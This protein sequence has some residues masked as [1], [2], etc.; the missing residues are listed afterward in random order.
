M[1]FTF[2]TWNAGSNE[3]DY[4]MSFL[5]RTD[6]SAESPNISGL[7]AKS[8]SEAEIAADNSFIHDIANVRERLLGEVAKDM[9]RMADVLALQ[10][11]SGYALNDAFGELEKNVVGKDRPDIENFVKAEFLI[12]RPETNIVEPTNTDTAI[13]INPKKFEAIENRSFVPKMGDSC[14]IAVATEKATG[15]RI[16]F[17]SG[18]MAGV[19]L[20]QGKESDFEDAQ[21]GDHYIRDLLKY[22]DKAFLDCDTII[23]GADVNA[24]PEIYK[25]R[26]ELFEEA[27]FSV[28]RTGKPTQINRKSTTLPERELDYV[29]VRQKP[30]EEPKQNRFI[31]FLSN[32][33]NKRTVQV[34]QVAPE[35]TKLKLDPGFCPSDHIPVFVTV[36]EVTRKGIFYPLISNVK[37]QLGLDQL[38]KD[39]KKLEAEVDTYNYTKFNA[40]GDALIHSGLLSE[41]SRE[42]LKH[43][44]EDLNELNKLSEELNK[45]KE[46]HLNADASELSPRKQALLKRLEAL[47]AIIQKERKDSIPKDQETNI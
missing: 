20:E 17:V 9:A 14:A 32:L 12:I 18:H 8:R 46:G 47:E 27:G 26:F 13:A 37:K 15:K 35:K 45:F 40:L 43:T 38:T 11:V 39:L 31:E 33:F 6:A 16:A 29:F 21:I 2:G 36:E 19:R 5:P 28:H 34:T 7:Y 23:V 10:E 42:P 24:S 1:G 22:L 4:M 3:A 30:K 44:P 41:S 25:K